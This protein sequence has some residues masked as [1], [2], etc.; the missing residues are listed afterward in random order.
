MAEFVVNILSKTLKK[1]IYTGGKI[2]PFW[3]HHSKKISDLLWLPVKEPIRLRRDNPKNRNQTQ[4]LRDEDK[5]TNFWNFLN[6][7]RAEYTSET[8]M[9]A[10][11]IRFY[12]NKNQRVYF[13]K[14]FGAHRYFYNEALQY[15]K[16][17]GALP[18]YSE[19]K[20]HVIPLK[21]SNDPN[22]QWM[23]EIPCC[24]K[25]LAVQQY[26]IS[27]KTNLD[28]QFKGDLKSFEMKLLSKKTNDDVCYIDNRTLDSDFK[29]FRRNKAMKEA[30]T[31]LKLGKYD[32]RWVKKNITNIDCGSVIIKDKNNRY[33]ICLI[34]EMKNIPTISPRTSSESLAQR[35][36]NE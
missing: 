24:V 23:L 2:E 19:I 35:R 29:I 15:V 13:N 17:I 6:F 26:H 32:K 14:L 30:G 12:P 18:K 33:Y 1:E 8:S 34:R 36:Q 10:K 11:K 4:T 31:Q 22:H 9:V 28:K 20:T 21:E 25:Q 3:N 7:D 5:K 27:H 16:Q